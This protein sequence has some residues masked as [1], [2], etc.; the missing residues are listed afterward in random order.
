MHTDR[1]KIYEQSRRTTPCAFETGSGLDFT[2]VEGAESKRPD[3]KRERILHLAR[4]FLSAFCAF[5]W[6]SPLSSP[7]QSSGPYVSAAIE[8]DRDGIFHNEIFKLTLCIS[9]AGLGLGQNFDLTSLPDRNLLCLEEFKELPVQQERHDGQIHEI[10]R[11]RCNARAIKP[12]TI[13]ISPEL[14]FTILTRE[15]QGF[16]MTTVQTQQ[17]I[18]VKPLTLTITPIPE[19][20]KP[21]D[22]SGVVGQFSFDIEVAPCEVAVGDLITAVMKI[23]GSGYLEEISQPRISPGRNFKV[24][25]PKLVSGTG[26][27][28][29]TFEQII[30]PQSTNAVEISA[31]SFSF[32]D[33]RPNSY[34]TI[35]KGPF[36][37]T[38]HE[39]KSA[40]LKPYRPSPIPEESVKDSGP[41]MFPT[42]FS[43][44][45]AAALR[46]RF[47]GSPEASVIK[48]EIARLAPA[49]SSVASF[50][51]PE[52]SIVYVL[53]THGSWAKISF[54]NKR[55]WIPRASLKM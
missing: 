53:E 17:K 24:Y 35:T 33:P 4:T 31:I 45:L 32:F 22:F 26:P 29:K 18:S 20:G 41:A 3:P 14:G 49:H 30:I 42:S 16:F 6:L 44:R 43:E 1:H 23:R 52:G 21:S 9:S 15:R 54:G 34:K 8:A 37:L 39:K 12:G 7:A 27:D 48:D 2:R 25:D 55:G 11:F 46:S 50:D 47:G 36:P 5:L 19:S 28:E 40:A 51:L 38:F 10:R 13:N